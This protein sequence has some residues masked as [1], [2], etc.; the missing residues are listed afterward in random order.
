MKLKKIATII[1]IVR[2]TRFTAANSN[3]RAKNKLKEINIYRNW[4]RKFMNFLL[5]KKSRF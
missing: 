4:I 2:R 3:L 5:L 1:I